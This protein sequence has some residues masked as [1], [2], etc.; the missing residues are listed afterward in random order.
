M[1]LPK[2][3]QLLLPV[4]RPF[5]VASLVVALA[6]DLLPLGRINWTPDWVMVLLVFWSLHQ[7]RS[8]GM[9]VAFVLGLAL[10]VDQSTLLG[11]HALVYCMLVFGVQALQRRL[12]WFGPWWQALQLLPLFAGA[13]L[14][15]LVLR[16][17]GSGVLPGWETALAPLLEA[18][19]WPLVSGLLLAPQRRP[20][21]QDENRPL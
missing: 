17:L 1:I 21:D 18:L 19:I 2:G 4:S 11:Q 13:H 8:V 5:M 7:P 6:L 9:G 15:E 14:L 12:L 10:D 20:P 3:Q 16:L